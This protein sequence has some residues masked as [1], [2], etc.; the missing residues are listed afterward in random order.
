MLKK[1]FKHNELLIMQLQHG[2]IFSKIAWI[3]IY[4]F[5]NRNIKEKE[6]KFTLSAIL[7]GSVAWPRLARTLGRMPGGCGTA[8]TAPDV[9]WLLNCARYLKKKMVNI[10]KIQRNDEINVGYNAMMRSFLEGKVY[11][12][13]NHK[14]RRLAKA[15]SICQHGLPLQVTYT[16]TNSQCDVSFWSLI[17][18]NTCLTA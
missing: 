16:S 14:R 12:Y 7:C 1:N 13:S 9:G 10:V 3:F 2:E 18:F 8:E 5:H 11:P 4:R 17:S 6:I 15:L